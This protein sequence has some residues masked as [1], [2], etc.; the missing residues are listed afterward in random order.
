MSDEKKDT[1]QAVDAE[2]DDLLDS[3]LEDLNKGIPK[4]VPKSNE[5][6]PAS[7]SDP[8][9]DVVESATVVEEQ[10]SQDFIKQAADQFEKN[11]Q[12]LIQ[13]GGD[14]EMGACFQKMAQ[15][16][17]SAVTGGE[18]IDTENS[19]ADFQSAIAQALKDLSATSENLQ[20]AGPALT[21]ADLAAMFEQT[22]LD[23]GAGN[24]LPFMQVV[25]QTLL[26]KESLYPSL[27]ELVDKYP[28]WLEKK[29]AILPPADFERYTK[30]LDYMRKTC[31]ELEK[32]KEDD[33]EEVKKKRF[34]KTL[35]LMQEMQSCGQPPADLV[36]EQSIIQFDGEGN[37]I[38][39]SLPSGIDSPQNC[40][41][42]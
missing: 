41:V 28:A 22:S 27:K 34:E 19:N 18:G 25:M 10:W 2:L 20:N 33:S 6:S 13:N 3:A 1:E 21:E 37:P 17:A 39:P 15:T 36:G 31:E 5:V 24:I 16:V 4:P 42:M 30:Q 38:M 32:E 40:C 35:S 7:A 8:A 23:E 26:S 29:K 14:S 11:L 9:K 12:E